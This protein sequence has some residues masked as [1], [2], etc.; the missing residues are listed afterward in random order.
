MTT[1]EKLDKFI[2]NAAVKTESIAIE[3]LIKANKENLKKGTLENYNL[4]DR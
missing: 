4:F 1:K 2:E 3:D